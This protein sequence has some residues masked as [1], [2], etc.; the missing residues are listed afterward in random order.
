MAVF[1]DGLDGGIY[2]IAGGA[3]T[4]HG[5]DRFFGISASLDMPPYVFIENDRFTGAGVF[6]RCREQGGQGG[7]RKL[8][9]SDLCLP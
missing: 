6:V 2:H 5:F 7:W 8:E 4:R 3:P 1:E 9:R